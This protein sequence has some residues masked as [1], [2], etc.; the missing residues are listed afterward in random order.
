MLEV[1]EMVVSQGP[2]L[3]RI[4]SDY[5]ESQ[6]MPGLAEDD[7]ETLLGRYEGWGE[8][9]RQMRIAQDHREREDSARLY[10]LSAGAASGWVTITEFGGSKAFSMRRVTG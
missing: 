3:L 9:D 6:G 1:K 2:E 10:N 5:W 4:Y 8:I 7:I